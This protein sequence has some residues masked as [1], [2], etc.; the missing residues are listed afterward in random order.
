MAV[1]KSK[2]HLDI[3][4]KLRANEEEWK[5]FQKWCKAA[6]M[7]ASAG[8]RK[9]MA[10]FQKNL[11][12]YKFYDLDENEITLHETIQRLEEKKKGKN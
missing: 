5:E 9:G 1:K 12:K 6:G 7:S 8:I 2:G 10:E 3:I 4:I 11:E